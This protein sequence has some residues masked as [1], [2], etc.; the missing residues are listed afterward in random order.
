MKTKMFGIILLSAMLLTSCATYYITPQSLQS[1][2]R[3]AQPNG[4]FNGIYQVNCVDKNGAEKVLPVTNH[5]GVRIT[6]KDDTRQTFYFV[7]AFLQD[8]I[9]TG[10]KSTFFPMPIKPINVNDI[11]KIEFQH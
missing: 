8:S 6:K 4:Q 9:V 7:T 10:S 5:T 3:K 2:L 1:Q 11:K